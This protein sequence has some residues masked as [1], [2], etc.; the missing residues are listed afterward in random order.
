MR[1]LISFTAFYNSFSY[2]L[3]PSSFISLIYIPGPFLHYSYIFISVYLLISFFRC[4][5]IDH[6]YFLEAW[7]QMSISR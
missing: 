3:F 7:W 6:F 2:P 4:S 1:A 5:I